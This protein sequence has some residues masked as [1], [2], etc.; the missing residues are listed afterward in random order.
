MLL[1]QRHEEIEKF[2]KVSRRSTHLNIE[3]G[4]DLLPEFLA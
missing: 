4:L 3:F 1:G 2:R